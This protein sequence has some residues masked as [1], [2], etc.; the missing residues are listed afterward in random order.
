MCTS[1]NSNIIYVCIS[2]S[3]PMKAFLLLNAYLLI[4]CVFIQGNVTV[5]FFIHIQI[6]NKAFMQEI[7]KIP[8]D[9][10]KITLE[11]PSYISANIKYL[12]HIL[13]EC[14]M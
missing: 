8:T 5:I 4:D 13:K 3:H 6:F 9:K 12:V 2:E 7:F 11:V 14:N 10:L 1:E